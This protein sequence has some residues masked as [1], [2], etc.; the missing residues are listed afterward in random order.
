MTRWLSILLAV[1]LGGLSP[2]NAHALTRAGQAA[3]DAGAS[4]GKVVFVAGITMDSF[5]GRNEDPLSLHKYLYCDANP[6]NRIDPS[7]HLTSLVELN[8]TTLLQ[9]GIRGGAFNV[10]AN[11]ILSRL[12]HEDY[13]VKE[14]LWDFATGAVLAGANL[15]VNTAAKALSS[16]I[17]ISLIADAVLNIGP[18]AV[19]GA[20][21]TGEYVLKK[22]NVLHQD[23]SAGQVAM[24][25]ALS[26]T[27][28]YF[29]WKRELMSEQKI[30]AAQHMIEELEKLRDGAAESAYGTFRHIWSTLAPETRDALEQWAQAVQ[31]NADTSVYFVLMGK[32]SESLIEESTKAAGNE[33]GD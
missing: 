8:I 2:S 30:E 27:A 29:L 22:E 28:N 31:S 14:G 13:T 26:T 12:L 6:I 23:V 7:G 20:L 33:M 9:T 19:A 25:F 32:L 4:L 15:G 16:K 11:L 1:V 21:S 3:Y 18:P 17:G 5:E 24:V 10:T